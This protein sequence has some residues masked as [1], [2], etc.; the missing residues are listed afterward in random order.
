MRRIPVFAALRNRRKVLAG[1]VATSVLPAA[2]WAAEEAGKDRGPVAG[3]G[4][5]PSPTGVNLADVAGAAAVGANDKSGGSLFTT[6]QG[7]VS[8]LLSSVGA[9]LVGFV[10]AG[11]GATARSV[12]SKL[13]DSVSV[14]DFGATGDGTT[15]DTAA[16]NA[17]I[18]HANSL[19]NGG[20]VYF[21]VGAYAVSEINATAASPT[22]AA[23]LK[24][25]GA[26]RWMTRIIP[27]APGRVL[28]NLLGR[29]DFILEDIQFD[30]SA[31]VSQCAIF[32]AR[33]TTSAHCNNNKFSGVF[34]DGSYSV[35]SVVCNGSESSVWN[36]CRFANVN[37]A[38]AYRCFWSGGG[39]GIKALQGITVANG[40][41]ILDSD[42]PNTDNRMFGVEFYAP[43]SRATPVR[44]S[45]S[46]EYQMFGCTVACGSTDHC[47]LVVYGDCTD[48]IFNGPVAWSGCHFEVYGTGNVVH[49]LDCTGSTGYFAGISSYGGFYNTCAPGMSSA[50]VVDFDRTNVANQPI[51]QGSTFT[52]PGTPSNTTDTKFYVYGLFGCNIS[53]QPNHADG[54][55][56]VFGYINSGTVVNAHTFNAGATRYVASLYTSV[57]S[58]LPTSGNFTVGQTIQRETPEVGQPLGWKCTV[59]GTLGTLGGI[60]GSIAAGSAVLRLNSAAGVAEGQRITV[61]GSGSGPYYIRQL[62]GTTAYLDSVAHA[63]VTGAAVAFSNATLVPLARL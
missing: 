21:P 16:I 13:R 20:E 58:D 6:V 11:S 49:Y 18:A 10:Q 57:A 63:T 26:G 31:L 48:G 44:F 29:D 3:R 42:N 37:A 40:G 47:R 32:M 1:M 30:S 27:I 35:A 56:F 62:A 8:Y 19:P 59:S 36:T 54:T 28:L 24:L 39:T 55:V 4:A 15:D 7:F 60:T 46:A 12:Q 61:T 53:I 22:F 52:S 23:T 50:A 38:A 2:A 25:R 5:A 17:A 43:F 33:S 34:V 45:I 51:L 9:G 41:T 14:K